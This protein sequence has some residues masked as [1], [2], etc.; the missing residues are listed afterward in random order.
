MICCSGYADILGQCNI[1][2]VSVKLYGQCGSL[3]VREIHTHVHVG[4]RVND[5]HVKQNEA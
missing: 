4:L 3:V 5:C 2:V 1:R